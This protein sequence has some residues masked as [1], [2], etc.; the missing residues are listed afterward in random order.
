[1]GSTPEER[2]SSVM[3]RM[4]WLVAV[5]TSEG[6]VVHT[7]WLSA[8]GSVPPMSASRRSTTTSALC[9]QLALAS[10]LGRS[11]VQTENPG[12]DDDGWLGLCSTRCSRRVEIAWKAVE[13][14]SSS[15]GHMDR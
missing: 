3:S 13:R 4:M 15:R 7:A 12:G 8:S 1:V 14:R 11:S 6:L 5:S 2:A 10:S 9:D